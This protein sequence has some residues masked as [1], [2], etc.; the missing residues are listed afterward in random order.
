MTRDHYYIYP[1]DK[2]GNKTGHTI[3][4]L[5]KDGKIFHGTSLCSPNDQFQYA[6]GRE[7]AMERALSAYERHLERTSEVR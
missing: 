4:V 5:M 1:T 3:C 7:I 2:N 6:R